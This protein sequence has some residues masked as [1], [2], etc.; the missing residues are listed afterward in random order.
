M[1]LI[2]SIVALLLSTAAVALWYLEW[3]ISQAPVVTV[4]KDESCECCSRW[5]RHMR[6]N[7][8]RVRL[9]SSTEGAA[10]RARYRLPPAMRACHTAV[11]GNLLIEGH[12]PAKDVWR[13]IAEPDGATGLIL[14]GMPRG[15]PGMESP[16][17]EAYTVLVLEP[18][19]TTRPFA[20]HER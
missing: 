5:V 8:F 12:V 17:R 14:P 19:G 9:G 18:S 6:M 4:Y 20:R 2:I 3:R 10:V 13:L 7:G 11:M 16:S 15:S 1:R